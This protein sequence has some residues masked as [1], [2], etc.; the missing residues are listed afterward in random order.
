MVMDK[1]ALQVGGALGMVTLI[2][3]LGGLLLML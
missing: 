3:G 1:W 2:S